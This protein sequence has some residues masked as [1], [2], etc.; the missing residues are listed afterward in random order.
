MCRPPPLLKYC[1]WLVDTF[2]LLNPVWGPCLFFP[3]LFGLG[4]NPPVGVGAEPGSSFFMPWRRSE[5]RISRR[6]HL[7]DMSGRKSRGKMD[8][9]ARGGSGTNLKCSVF[10]TCSGSLSRQAGGQADCTVCCSELAVA[11]LLTL[12][13]CRGNF[14][15][16]AS[17]HPAAVLLL[18]LCLQPPGTQ[19]QTLNP[20]SKDFY[21]VPP[22]GSSSCA[23]PRL[24]YITAGMHSAPNEHQ[25][26]AD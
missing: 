8:G 6:S 20:T 12:L 23:K 4:T 14:W 5:I 26:P 10:I 16:A 11:P 7:D 9:E 18:L 1:C 24:K 25:S 21:R 19:A 17:L 13:P 2:N 22:G 3:H 15:V